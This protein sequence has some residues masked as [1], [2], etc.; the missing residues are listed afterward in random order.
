M[1]YDRGR[2]CW[3]RSLASIRL[4]IHALSVSYLW[5]YL[6]VIYLFIY[7]NHHFLFLK[8]RHTTSTS[9]KS[10]TEYYK[11]YYESPQPGFSGGAW[12]CSVEE[13]RQALMNINWESCCG[14]HQLAARQD[15][16]SI[17]RFVET[18]KIKTLHK[19]NRAYKQTS[20]RES[21]KYELHVPFLYKTTT[22][23]NHQL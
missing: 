12:L 17:G 22:H 10:T 1:S 23:L 9:T 21:G 13:A 5:K 15:L 3:Q 16:G 20:K 2:F 6:N 4:I 7:L 11:Y 14:P 18:R 8:K 19:H